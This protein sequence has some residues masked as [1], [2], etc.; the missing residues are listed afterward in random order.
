MEKQILVDALQ[1]IIRR[2]N[3]TIEGVHNN[4]TLNPTG[5]QEG[6]IEGRVD[7]AK[8]A[9]DALEK[10]NPELLNEMSIPNDIT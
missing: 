7:Q 4:Q 1:K 6:L 2:S 8:I 9:V 10:V 5:R 3:D